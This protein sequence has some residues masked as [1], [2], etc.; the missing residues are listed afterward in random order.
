MGQQRFPCSAVVRAP[1][2][3]AHHQYVIE[4]QDDPRQRAVLTLVA[5]WRAAICE[6]KF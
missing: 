5:Q 4:A 3:S 2:S 1:T 6:E